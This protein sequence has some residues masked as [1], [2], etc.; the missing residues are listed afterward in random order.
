MKWYCNADCQK[1]DWPSHKLMCKTL[2]AR[3]TLSRAADF[4]QSLW[5]IFREKTNDYSITGIKLKDG[6]YYIQDGDCGVLDRVNKSYR[7]PF[8]N[9]LM[10]DESMKQALLT[11]MLCTDALG[12]MHNTIAQL[13]EGPSSLRCL[14]RVV[15]DRA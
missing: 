3:K 14:W 11:H 1:A 7:Y 13:L 4:L 5:Y 8:P 12:Y 15:A 2:S 9:E 6:I 10:P